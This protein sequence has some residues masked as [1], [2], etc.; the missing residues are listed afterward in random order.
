MPRVQSSS[1]P[2]NARLCTSPHGPRQD[3]LW[4]GLTFAKKLPARQP[5]PATRAKR[6]DKA[7][8]RSSIVRGSVSPFLYLCITYLHF[9]GEKQTNKVRRR[10]RRRRRKPRGPGTLLLGDA[11]DASKSRPSST[12]RAN[13]IRPSS[14]NK[15]SGGTDRLAGDKSALQKDGA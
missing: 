10:R 15:P 12:S 4:D 11:C 14:T 1:N 3:L 5:W 13:S 9:V 2:N 7:I 8:E 6:A